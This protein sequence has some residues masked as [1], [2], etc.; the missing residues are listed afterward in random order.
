MPDFAPGPTQ[1]AD[2]AAFAAT[3]TRPGLRE[4]TCFAYVRGEIVRQRRKCLHF[5]LYLID[6]EMGFMHV[7]IQ[8]W[9]PFLI[10]IYVNGREWL[11]R[12]LDKRNVRYLRYEQTFLRIDACEVATDVMWL[13]RRSLLGILDDVFD[14]A[15]RTFSARDVVR[16]WGRKLASTRR[17]SQR[18][19]V[20]SSAPS[21]P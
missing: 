19:N 21:W 20:L 6:P 12:Q 9:F 15:I 1:P 5:Y 2:T 7:R 4:C 10:Q 3:Q 11:S 16:F 13:N 8:S 18:S 17:P 14:H